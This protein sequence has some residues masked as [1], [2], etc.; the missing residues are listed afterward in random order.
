MQLIADA[1]E[2]TND[3]NVIGFL[4]LGGA[5]L[6]FFAVIFSSLLIGRGA[7]GEKANIVIF[8][9]FF[10]AFFSAV[11]ILWISSTSGVFFKTPLKVF[12]EGISLQPADWTGLRQAIAFGKL[13]FVPFSEI[14][15]VEFFMATL[16]D[17]RGQK[18]R[19][20]RITMSSGE[21][22]FSLEHFRRT[23]LIELV[24]KV[25]PH[26]GKLGFTET[27]RREEKYWLSYRFERI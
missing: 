10:L 24:G 20:C 25:S 7:M 4:G 12:D 23:G 22:I 11:A 3:F 17:T 9:Y 5:A 16:G 6:I 21:E 26:L 8:G 2:Y 13:T 18:G 15:K 1:K 19:G 14:S 27:E